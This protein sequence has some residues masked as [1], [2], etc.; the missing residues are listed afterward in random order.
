MSPAISLASSM[1]HV[2]ERLQPNLWQQL[3]RRL[4]ALGVAAGKL[5]VHISIGE[6]RLRVVTADGILR[7]Y[8]ASTGKNRPSCVEGSHGTPT[9]C[10]AIVE[11]YGDGLPS[12]AVLVAR[13]PTGKFF[14]DYDNSKGHGC[15]VT[16]ILRLGGLED[17]INRGIDGLGRNC[18]SFARYIYIHG[19]CFEEKVGTPHSGGCVTLYSDDIIELY[20]LCEPGTAVV[21]DQ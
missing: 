16:R 2:P 13:K 10:H 5:I 7:Y 11:K 14:W 4:R 3:V 20:E 15:V 9:G 6:Q 17:G 12:G 21:I 18:D 1:E 19:S 8:A